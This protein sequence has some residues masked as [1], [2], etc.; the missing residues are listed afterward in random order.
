MDDDEAFFAFRYTAR[1]G[2][3]AERVAKVEREHS[4]L[5]FAIARAVPWRVPFGN[6]KLWLRLPMLI[7]GLLLG[8]SVW[9]IGSRWYGAGSGLFALGLYCFSPPLVSVGAH[10]WPQAL[11]AWGFYGTVFTAMACAHTLY[12][13]PG[14]LSSQRRWRN[15]VLFGLALGVGVAADFAVALALPF[16]FAFA[17]Y[18]VPGRRWAAMRMLLSGCAMAAVILFAVYAFHP[19][20]FVQALVHARFASA[21]NWSLATYRLDVLLLWTSLPPLALMSGVAVITWLISRRARWFGNT[22]LL[23]VASILPLFLPAE[24]GTESRQLAVAIPFVALFIGGIFADLMQGR[25][26][27]MWNAVALLLVFTNAALGIRAVLR[28]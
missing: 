14:V 28:I 4:P 24:P 10:L 23:L 17:L 6:P 11:A 19:A 9:H 25:L 27:E 12:A 18:L 21:Q 5:I 15:V 7:V 13:A 20:A 2:W 1:Q 22:A 3:P 8:A 16:A 26:Q